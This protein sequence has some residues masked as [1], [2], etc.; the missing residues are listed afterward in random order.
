MDERRLVSTPKSFSTL[1][2]IVAPRAPPLILVCR[3]VE[4]QVT[5]VNSVSMVRNIRI[6]ME[7]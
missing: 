4:T 2:L 6:C 3:L 5:Q 7:I 1:K